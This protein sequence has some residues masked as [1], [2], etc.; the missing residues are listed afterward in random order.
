MKLFDYGWFKDFHGCIEELKSMAM[1]EDWDYKKNPIGKNPIL[2][3]Y[4]RHTFVKVYEEGKVLE[5]HGYAIFNTGLVTDY[6]EEIY[7]LFQKNRRPGTIQWFFIG[8]RKASD[9]ELMKFSCLLD[10]ANYFENSS[11]LIYDTRLELRPNVN[12]IIDNNI[13]RFPTALQT[14][15]KYQLGILLEGT[16]KDAIRR[17]RRN[18]KTAVGPWRRGGPLPGCTTGAPGSGSRHHRCTV[19]SRLR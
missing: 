11:D 17:I 16:I 10:N 13:A 2:E 19:R 12:H 3:N 1:K 7:G 6:Q 5:Q 15:D 18:Y 4:I 9:R 14:M 8:W